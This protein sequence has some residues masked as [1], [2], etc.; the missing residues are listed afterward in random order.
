MAQLEA[1]TV[2]GDVLQ[3]RGDREPRAVRIDVANDGYS[4]GRQLGRPGLEHDRLTRLVNVVEEKKVNRPI[5]EEAGRLL[6]GRPDELREASIACIVIV[7]NRFEPPSHLGSGAAY[8]DAAA[9]GID[10][11]AHDGFTE[12]EIGISVPHPNLH[13][14]A[15]PCGTENPEDEGGLLFPGR[16]APAIEKSKQQ[17]GLSET[18]GRVGTGAGPRGSIVAGLVRAQPGGELLT[19]FIGEPSYRRLSRRPQSTPCA[20]TC[21]GP[22]RA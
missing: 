17:R 15:R 3:E 16:A 19:P 1:G 11:E 10:A 5:S 6:T 4:A 2:V 21:P 13:Q 12:A 7:P 9:G 22:D 20:R 18:R 14:Q 8:I